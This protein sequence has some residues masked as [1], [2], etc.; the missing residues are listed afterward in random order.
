MDTLKVGM[1]DELVWE[2]TEALTTKRG[3][4]RVFSTPSMTYFVEMTAHKLV[5]PHLK[6]GQGQVGLQVN[7]RHMAPTPIGKSVRRETE[8]FAIDRRKLTFKMKVYDDVE[9]IGEAEHDRYIVDLEKYM[10]RL[11][12][13]IERASKS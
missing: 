5:L 2:V 12:A 9:Q 6:P 13:K 7:I 8:L 4:Y 1:R 10:A 3:D 11:K